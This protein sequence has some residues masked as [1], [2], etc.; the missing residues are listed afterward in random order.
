VTTPTEQGPAGV[1][2]EP[3]AETVQKM[4]DTLRDLVNAVRDEAR[5]KFRHQRA[6]ART[7]PPN[8]MFV[9]SQ[10][11]RSAQRASMAVLE[12]AVE[13]QVTSLNEMYKNQKQWLGEQGVPE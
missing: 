10:Q 13:A 2:W 3:S 1:P 6:L 12:K 11:W 5:A 4:A 7:T 8:E 9:V